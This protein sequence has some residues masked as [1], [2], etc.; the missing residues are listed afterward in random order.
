MVYFLIF[1]SKII[2][3]ALSTLRLIVVA[4]GKK[5]LG[6]ILQG[7]V[8]LVWIFVT[9]IVIVDINKDPIKIIIFCIGSIVGSYLGSLLEEKLGIGTNMLMCVI[10]EIYEQSLKDILKD[11]QI[12]TLCEKDENYS[13]LFIVLKRKEI[14]KISKIIK[15]I[16]DEAILISEKIK[17][18]TNIV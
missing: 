4:N 7:I 5:K 18:I 10:K 3:N 6:A 17:T 12:T 13:I 1:I 16:D 14:T 9:G 15:D 2:E 11:Y 8:A